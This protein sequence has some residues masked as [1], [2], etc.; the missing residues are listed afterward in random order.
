MASWCVSEEEEDAKVGLCAGEVIVLGL[1]GEE[2]SRPPGVES[3]EGMICGEEIVGEMGG[4]E[5]TVVGACGGE[6]TE[7]MT[8][9]REETVVVL[10][11]GEGSEVGTCGG[12]DNGVW[13]CSGEGT[14]GG[15]VNMVGL[16]D[17]EDTFMGLWGGTDSLVC[18]EVSVRAV[19]VG[20]ETVGLCGAGL[21]R[22]WEEAVGL[23]K[24]VLGL[25]GSCKL[26]LGL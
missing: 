11:T 20:E 18:G 3:L 2:V 7:V 25:H 17:G 5:G 15:E 19:F 16:C 26:A 4:G 10:W 6:E 1:V 22:L 9:C 21:L 8:E 12:E 23:C 24:V 14:S 13:L